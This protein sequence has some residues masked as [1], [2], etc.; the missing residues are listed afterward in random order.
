MPEQLCPACGCHIGAGA[1][2][3]EG[4]RYCYKPCA[5]TGQCDCSCCE[6][7]EEA[8]EKEKVEESH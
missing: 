5:T 3:K 7:V 6:I 2:E 4:V 1:Y 8:E